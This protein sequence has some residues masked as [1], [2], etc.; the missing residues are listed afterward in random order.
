MKTFI[1]NTAPA[2]QFDSNGKM[3][4]EFTYSEEFAPVP[5]GQPYS[6]RKVFKTDDATV[7]ALLLEA[8][9]IEVIA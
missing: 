4:W 1:Q 2:V 8:G 6:Y 7:Q 9:A 5:G 3:I